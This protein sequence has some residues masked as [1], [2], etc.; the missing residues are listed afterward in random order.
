L[1][2]SE[3][4]FAEG[5]TTDELLNAKGRELS[6]TIGRLSDD[7]ISLSGHLA[8]LN[9]LLERNAALDL[10][11]GQAR[12]DQQN[13]ENYLCELEEN[14][15]NQKVRQP[16]RITYCRAIQKRCFCAEAL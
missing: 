10:E 15:Q 16:P 2:D 1:A 9:S 7:K 14:L 5:Q 4:L 3:G 8:Q 6:G 11:I 12:E 13:K